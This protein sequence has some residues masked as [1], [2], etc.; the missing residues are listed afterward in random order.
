MNKI[1]YF[2]LAIFIIILIGA[3][4][5]GAF[6][7]YQKTLPTSTI[8]LSETVKKTIKPDSGSV[9]LYVNSDGTDVKKLNSD[10]DVVVSKVVDYLISSGISKDKI[11]SNKNSYQDQIYDPSGISKD[12]IYRMNSN[13]DISFENLNLDINSILQKSLEYGVSSF[14]QVNFEIKDQQKVCEELQNEAENKLR[15]KI[16]QK[17]NNLG[18][19]VASVQY[20]Q[21][22]DCN[23]GGMYPM[24]MYAKSASDSSGVIGE[25]V[26]SGGQK[27]LNY[28]A[29]ANITYR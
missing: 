18:F 19:K 9:S 25:N 7:L 8:T 14:G 3:T 29:T 22:Y 16:T 1:L 24:P 13:I 4:S 28:T 6:F 27:E 26:L 12:K 15:E 21:G 5:F 10:N 23:N 2:L 20:T 17:S 11:K